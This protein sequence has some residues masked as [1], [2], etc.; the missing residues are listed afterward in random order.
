MRKVQILTA[1]WK[2]PVFEDGERNITLPLTMPIEKAP[3]KL[4]LTHDFSF[5]ADEKNSCFYLETRALSGKCTVFIDGQKI[6][7]FYSLFAPRATTLTEYIRKGEPQILRLEIEPAALPDGRFTFGGAKLVSTRQA[8]FALNDE[9][10]AV[11]VRTVFT[12]AGVSLLMHAEVETP[13]NYDVVLFRLCAPDGTLI[14]TKSA[15][16]TAADVTFALRDPLLWDGLH[17]PYKYRAEVV[18]QRDSDIIDVVNVQFGIRRFEASPAGFFMLNGVNLPLSGVM[19]RDTDHIEADIGCLTELDANLVGL[20]MLDFD[21]KILNRCDELGLM[22]FFRFPCTGDDRDFEELRALTQL[23]A[24][25]PSAAFL[26]FSSTDPG[27][28]KKF[29]NT[30][31]EN[32]QQIFTVGL[33]DLF[34]GDAISDAIPDVLF[35]PYAVSPEKTGFTDLQ[36]QF[37]E[38]L[39]QHPDYRFAVFP[40]APE[41]LIDRHSTGAQRPDCSQ[42]YFSMWHE[43]VWNIFSAHKNVACYFTGWL[44]DSAVPG[45]R[46]GLV[47]S[48][49]EDR[50][51]AFWYYKGQ[52]SAKSFL[53][54]ASLPASV[55]RKTIDVICYT[56]EKEITLVLNDKIKKNYLPERLSENVYCFREIPLQRK[57]NKLV[58]MGPSGTDAAEIYRS[59][60]TLSKK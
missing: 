49:R 22:V 46:N 20:D 6:H 47:T 16:P 23:L 53:K 8:H 59:K 2:E 4:V 21:E 9:T 28:G 48:E 41:C 25:H 52:F 35:L 37:E 18:L 54:L 14:D 44:T 15:K 36:K 51:D 39:S 38:V 58:V 55:T 34:N 17:A 1:G 24:A 13:N 11:R 29:C 56:N 33:C 43:K 45:E 31:K 50:K 27:Y 7:S 10:E 40:D 42:E 12:E 30:V 19:L 3:E 26:Y 57:E 60:S 32:A 5:A